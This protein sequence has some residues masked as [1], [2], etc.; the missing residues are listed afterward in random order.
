MCL[1]KIKKGYFA[2]WFL[3]FAILACSMDFG[4]SPASQPQPDPN[5]QILKDSI[6][7][8]EA[9]I[10]AGKQKQQNQQNQQQQPQQNAQRPPAPQNG[11]LP[12][13]TLQ[14]TY[15]PQATFTP[16]STVNSNKVTITV[17]GTSGSKCR[18][19]PGKDYSEVGIG[20]KPGQT[21]EVIG[22][23]KSVYDYLFVKLDDGKTCWLFY[24]P[25]EDTISGNINNLPE[26][27]IPAKPTPTST[28]MTQEPANEP[29]TKVFQLSVN[30][31]CN[32]D[33]NGDV[34]AELE[35]EWL[36]ADHVDSPISL[37]IY[38]SASSFRTSRSRCV[39]LS[40]DV[41]VFRRLRPS[42]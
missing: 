33:N 14:P 7:T 17:N 1:H 23:N 2:T 28:K 22:K 6:A 24:K 27:A 35:A 13:Y 15:T 38:P 41:L 21:T 30:G 19:G 16:G 4:D 29:P 8:N 34:Y 39:I 26:I 3:L 9:L 5:D 18:T 12:T 10:Q 42:R 20:L 36:D 11:A 25:T 37:F 32:V 31:Y 40:Q